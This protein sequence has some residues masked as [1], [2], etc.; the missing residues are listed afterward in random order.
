MSRQ[1]EAK[2]K[3]G[4]TKQMK[5]CSTCDNLEKETVT[6]RG[7]FSTYTK[8]KNVRCTIGGFAVSKFATCAHWRARQ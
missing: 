5:V 6:I 8:D 7:A 2:V 4:Y 3:Q 1:S